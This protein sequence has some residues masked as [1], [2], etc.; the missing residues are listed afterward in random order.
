LEIDNIKTKDQSKVVGFILDNMDQ[1]GLF[2]QEPSTFFTNT[3]FPKWVVQSGEI[4]TRRQANRN[5]RDWHLKFD[6]DKNIP[7]LEDGEPI[8]FKWVQTIKELVELGG[9]DVITSE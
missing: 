6:K 8:R 2:W 9:V 7:Y 3:L 5:K 4:M 1:P